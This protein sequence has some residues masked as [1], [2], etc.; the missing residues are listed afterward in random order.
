[1]GSERRGNYQKLYVWQRSDELTKKVFQ[2]TKQF[3][4]EER[5]ELTSQ[6]RRAT[7]SVTLN[8][9]E[10][11]TRINKR[12]FKQ[13]LNIALG[14]LAETEYLIDLSA[15]LGYMD[16]RHRDE[17]QSLRDET[18]KLLWRLIQSID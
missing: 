7:L 5:Y 12:G 16:L 8:I 10:G 3:P 15:D 13:F 18:G 11:Y 1:M 9:V 14:S 6:L 17:T 4:K 2:L